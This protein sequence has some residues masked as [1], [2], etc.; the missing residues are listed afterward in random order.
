[1]MSTPEQRFAESMAR[2]RQSARWSQ[3]AVAGLLGERYGVTIHQMQ[4]SKIERAAQAIRLDQAAPIAK[5]FGLTLDEMLRGDL[6]GGAVEH[7]GLAEADVRRI[8]EEMMPNC[9]CSRDF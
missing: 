7:R 8:V 2:A 4:L 9:R 1:M 5:L 3:E 6:D